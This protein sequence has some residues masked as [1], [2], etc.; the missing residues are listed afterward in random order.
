MTNHTIAVSD[1]KI[2]DFHHYCYRLH[3]VTS[4]TYKNIHN[5]IYFK[6]IGKTIGDNNNNM[7]LYKIIYA[8]D[9]SNKSTSRQ[10]E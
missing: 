4:V 10:D 8:S 2:F 5:A 6:Y 7:S 9:T 3:L 1:F